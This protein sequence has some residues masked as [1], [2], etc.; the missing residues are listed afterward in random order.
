MK[1]RFEELKVFNETHKVVLEI[2]KFSNT[3]PSSENFALKSQLR[4]SAVSIAANIV[5]GNTR[6]HKKEFLQFLYISQGSLEETKYHLLLAKDLRY[7]S[8]KD[9]ENLQDR[10]E[11]VGK[12]IAGLIKYWNTNHIS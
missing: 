1:N 6:I 9:Y 7:I 11:I 2:Y 12:M 10:L 5:E 8:Q 3:F 4:R